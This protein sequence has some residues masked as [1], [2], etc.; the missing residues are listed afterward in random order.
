[1]LR[2]PNVTLEKAVALGQSREQ[3][4]IHAKELK[5]VAEIYRIKFN[6][7]ETRYLQPEKNVIERC[8][9]CGRTHER[10]MP[11]ISSNLQQLS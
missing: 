9:Y 10:S 5:E 8:K 6:K 4:K 3:M 11:C 7:K 2:E 1:M